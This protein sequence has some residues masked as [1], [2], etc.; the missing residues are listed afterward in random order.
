MC[1]ITARCC[2]ILHTA[3]FNVSLK[4][5]YPELTWDINQPE[6]EELVEFGKLI[7]DGLQD[8]RLGFFPG[9]EGDGSRCVGKLLVFLQR[10]HWVIGK[11]PPEDCNITKMPPSAQDTGTAKRVIISGVEYRRKLCIV[12]ISELLSIWIHPSNEVDMSIKPDVLHKINMKWRRVS[13]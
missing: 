8:N 13:Y 6:D 1:T 11:Q 4:S 2:Q 5:L 10:T 7:W 3:L 9:S 12:K